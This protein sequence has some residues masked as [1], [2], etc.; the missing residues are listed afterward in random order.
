M[1]RRTR[2]ANPWSWP[3]RENAMRRDIRNDV[4]IKR[5]IK[6]NGDGTAEIE[7]S[8]GKVATVKWDVLH[9]RPADG[10]IN[11]FGPNNI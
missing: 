11:S 9:N 7:L 1:K 10:R 2:E 3:T 6:L 8:A 5:L 4:T